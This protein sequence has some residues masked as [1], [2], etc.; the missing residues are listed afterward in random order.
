MNQPHPSLIRSLRELPRAAWILFIGTF[1]NKFGAFVMPFLTIY[2]TQ[3]GFSL[4]ATGCAVGAYGAGYWMAS[5]LG[6]Y[7]AD[8][9]GRR[10]TIVISMFS[11]A[12]AMLLLS[13]ATTAAA[14]IGL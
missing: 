11:S 8:S 9:I 1:L 10:N 7:L 5:L 3:R 13:Q 2:L 14:M 4:T 6:G 12:A